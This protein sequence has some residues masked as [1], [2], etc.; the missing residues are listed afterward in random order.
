MNGAGISDLVVVLPG[1]M[2]SELIA[3]D[4]TPLWSTSRGG[5]AATLASLGDTVRRLRLP[6]GIG[7]DHPDDGVE[8][9][10]LLPDLVALPGLWRP[11]SGYNR[12]LAALAGPGFDLQPPD[13][14]TPEL[15]PNLV[16]YPYDWRLSCRYN[17][18]RLA[19]E[20]LPYLERWRS[21]PGMA[22]SELVIIAHSMGGLVAR[23]F[24]QRCGGAEVTRALITLGTPFR[25]AA[26]ALDTLCNGMTPG[27]GP[28]QFDLTDVVRSFPS[29]YQLLPTYDCVV[30]SASQTRTSLLADVPRDLDADSVRDASDFHGDIVPT[31]DY[32]THKLVGAFQRTHVTAI[33]ENGRLR[34]IHTIDGQDDGGDG[35]VPAISREPQ[36]DRQ[37]QNLVEYLAQHGELQVDPAVLL[38]IRGILH[39]R[40]IVTQTTTDAPFGLLHE[41][42]PPV[43][44]PWTVEITD[45]GDRIFEAQVLR[46]DDDGEVAVSDGGPILEMDPLPVGRYRVVVVPADESAGAVTSPIEVLPGG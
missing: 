39:R 27:I 2:G 16:P 15:M 35:T 45:P 4:H 24:L 42:F 34:T 31:G 43:G 8:A 20:I 30:D 40:Q 23:W 37:G 14:H 3:D 19:E 10:R 38:Q 21:L 6:D 1:I 12:Q 28:L 25:G 7:D 9:S 17:G 18:Q 46:D 36:D 33:R 29:L 13:P 41:D 32:D 44:R 26:N 11:I 22:G 5:I